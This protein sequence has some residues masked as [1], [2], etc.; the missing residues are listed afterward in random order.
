MAEIAYSY[1]EVDNPLP[2]KRERLEEE[3]EDGQTYEQRV[4]EFKNLTPRERKVAELRKKLKQSRN[5]NRKAVIEEDQRQHDPQA[6]A[7]RRKLEYYEQQESERR[8]MEEK[9]GD[10]EKKKLLNTTAEAAE[11]SLKK[12]EKKKARADSSFGWEKFGTDAQYNAF[13]KR[14]KDSGFSKEEY[15]KKKAQVEAKGG[16]FY[17]DADY[18]SYGQ[19]SQAISRDK[20]NGMRRELDK[21]FQRRKE[22]SRRRTHLED[23]DVTYIN[24]RNRKFNKKLSR[25]YDSYT[26][27]I[28]QNL[29]RGTAL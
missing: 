9:G 19:D 13:K 29:E 23:E 20:V 25:A 3:E 14:Q 27:E 15:D 18:L 17:R 5:E 4:E 24:D 8:E 2:R 11:G 7:K 10:Y 6:E 1:S 16:D 26:S 22:F 21:V 12:K 28:K